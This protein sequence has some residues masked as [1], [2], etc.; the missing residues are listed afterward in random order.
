MLKLGPASER[1]ELLAMG[2][3]V[4]GVV[5]CTTTLVLLEDLRGMAWETTGGPVLML[6]PADPTVLA[7]ASGHSKAHASGG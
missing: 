1:T 5:P 3:T 2:L 6:C 4:N 7:G